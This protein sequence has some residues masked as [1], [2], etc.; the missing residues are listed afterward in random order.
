MN[1]VGSNWVYKMKQCL[2]VS[3]KRHKTRL[4]AKGFTLQEGIDYSKTLSLVVM[5]TTIRL[6]LTIIVSRVVKPIN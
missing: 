2:N 4:V 5:P 6:V 1:M 3:V